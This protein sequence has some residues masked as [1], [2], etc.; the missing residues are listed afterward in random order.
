MA[1]ALWQASGREA[2]IVD[3]PWP[4]V[5]ESALVKDEVLYI[6]QVNG[7]MRGKISVAADLDKEAVEAMALTNENVTKFT[8]GK[9][10]RKTIVV[11]G[12][13]VNIVAN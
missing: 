5:D 9:T 2:L 7:K 6:L 3:H 12:R 4:Q 1:Q 8:E 11:P 10:V 13:L